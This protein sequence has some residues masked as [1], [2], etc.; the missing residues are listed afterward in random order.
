M[1]RSTMA[2][3]SS[4]TTSVRPNSMISAGGAI[5]VVSRSMT[6]SRVIGGCLILMEGVGNTKCRAA[7]RTAHLDQPQ[8][9]KA[10]DAV[11]ADDD[12]VMNGDCKAPRGVD[13]QARHRDVGI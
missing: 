7:T 8:R 10:G 6:R 4:N 3:P 13:D 11:P 12:M 5:P 9:L 1:G 2:W